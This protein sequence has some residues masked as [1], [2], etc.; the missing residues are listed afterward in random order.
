MP[1]LPSLAT[2]R[3]QVCLSFSFSFFDKIFIGI[4]Q[5]LAGFMRVTGSKQEFKQPLMAFTKELP[6]MQTLL[7]INFRDIYISNW[8]NWQHGIITLTTVQFWSS[9]RMPWWNRT[10]LS[11]FEKAC[12]LPIY[13][14][15]RHLCS[16]DWFLFFH[17]S[18]QWGLITTWK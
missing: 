2:W 10:K 16:R 9:K 13:P 7:L 8:K 5:I 1:P 6:K 12:A 14:T 4:N 17:C 18:L 3:S 15:V 11:L